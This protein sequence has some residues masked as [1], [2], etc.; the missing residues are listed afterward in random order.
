MKPCGMDSIRFFLK[1]EVP[2]MNESELIAYLAN[3]APTLLSAVAPFAGSILT[4][5][6][7][8]SNT[9][10]TEFE[11][12]KAGLFNEVIEDL[13]TSGQMTYTEFYKAKNFLKIAKKAD[14]YYSQRQEETKEKIYDFDWF[15][16]YYEAAGNISD[17]DMQDI[18]AKVLAGEISNPSFFSLKIIDILRNMRKADAE[19]FVRFCK[20]SFSEG[21]GRIFLPNYNEYL[22]KCGITYSDVMR[23]S[24]MGLIFN[25]ALISL[26]FKISQDPDVI[27][28]NGDYIMTLAS[29]NKNLTDGSIKQYPFTK[30]GEELATLV[31][32][33]PSVE[34][35]IDFG[36]NIAKSDNYNVGIHKIIHIDDD[37]IEYEDENILGM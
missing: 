36:K 33:C 32:D 16:R 30:V 1:R 37:N 5:V 20:F 21:S 14:A 34:S 2:K 9:A 8:K 18:W 10:T 23:L 6:F 12:I 24:E 4:A 31:S 29:Q 17:D 13:L 28:I 11:K 27:F 35:F 19:L 3:N 7:L 26:Q 25:D 22:D 15:M